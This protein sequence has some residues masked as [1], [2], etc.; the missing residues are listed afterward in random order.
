MEDIKQQAKERIECA[1]DNALENE[2]SRGWVV[3][4]KQLLTRITDESISLAVAQERKRVT[5]GVKDITI[6]GVGI[7]QDPLISKE[8]VLSLINNN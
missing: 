2:S 4:F 1:I 6:F 7:P 3:T 5:N 8:S